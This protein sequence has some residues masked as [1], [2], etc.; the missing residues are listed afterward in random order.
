MR[1]KV[2]EELKTR[3][4][5]DPPS[6]VYQKMYS[7]IVFGGIG[8]VCYRRCHHMTRC[9]KRDSNGLCYDYF[10]LKARHPPPNPSHDPISFRPR[11]II[12]TAENTIRHS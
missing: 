2:S 10:C 6:Y 5:P 11:A 3:Y 8:G 9:N 1:S 12:R 4:M 7:S